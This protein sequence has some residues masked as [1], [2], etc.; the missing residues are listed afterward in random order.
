MDDIFNKDF[1]IS[2]WEADQQSDTHKV[3]K[4]FSTPEY[5]DKAAVTY[6]TDQREIRNRRLEKTID[7]FKRNRLIWDGMKVLDIGCGT[8]L[9]S[10]DLARQGAQVTALDFSPRML[11]RFQEDI[12]SHLTK[13][14]TLLCKD[15]LTVNIK[16]QGWE[17]E[18]D[19]V[20]AFMSP[21]VA[22]P[23]ALFK[24]MA[25]SKNGCAIR[26]WAAKRA[27]PILSDL[28]EKIIGTPL[29]DK[30]QSILYKINLLFSMGFFPEI[31]FDTIE[32]EQNVSI[33]DELN[34][35]MAF[36]K[37]VSKKEDE[38]LEAIISSYLK[39][40]A[41]KDRIVRKHSGLTATALWTKK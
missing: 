27:H 35:Q 41:Q 21:G 37:R 33:Q 6:N 1:W 10:L 32:W 25:C 16:K 22:T 18:F 2:Q 36:F 3:H 9:F 34:N 11:D 14:I 30:P 40:I 39:K 29:E 26:G 15:W 12:P 28:W 17:S 13:K 5:W 20:V 8:G 23:D 19:L 24:M 38:E 7:F 31:T 4:G